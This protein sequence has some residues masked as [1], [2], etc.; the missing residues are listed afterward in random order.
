M[1]RLGW[2]GSC[3]SDDNLSTKKIYPGYQFPSKGKKWV[4]RLRTTDESMALFVERVQGCH[5]KNPQYLR[6]KLEM[7]TMEGL[8][9]RAAALWHLAQEIQLVTPL[10]R[11]LLVEHWLQAWADGS[12]HVDME[13]Q[14]MLLDKNDALDISTIPTFK[15]LLDMHLFST[16]V[17]VSS[18]QAEAIAVDEFNLVMKQIRYDVQVFENW[19]KK[20][21]NVHSAREHAKQEHRLA[22]HQLCAES[23]QVFLE[24]CVKFTCWTNPEGIIGEIM[25]FR[26]DMVARKLGCEVSK[27]PA[28]VFLNWSA[29]C[30]IASTVYD[31]QSNV[32][33][34]ATNDNMQSVGIVLYPVFTYAK[35]KLHLEETKVT[36][37]L[38]RANH[39]IDIQFSI[40][41]ADQVDGRDLRPMVYPGRF[42]FPSP[43][44]DLAKSM[45]F[46]CKL[47]KSRRTDEIKQ[48]APKNMKEIEDLSA[49]ALPPSIDLSTSRVQG[50]GKYSQ[51]GAAA[52]HAV[53]GSTLENVS[54]SEAPAVIVLD[55][56]PR[57][58]DLAEAFCK[59][60]SLYNSTTSLFYFGVC[61]DQR[62]ADWITTSLKDELIEGYVSGASSLPNN[63]KL[64]KDVADDLLEPLPPLPKMNL[65]IVSGSNDEQKR[66]FMPSTL[67]KKWQFHPLFG[68]EFLN[69]LDEFSKKHSVM[70]ETQP[71][72]SGAG[73]SPAKRGN[74][75]GEGPETPSKKPKLDNS[76]VV[77]SNKIEHALLLEAKVVTPK[78]NIALQIRAGHRI[79]ICNKAQAEA[80]LEA[81]SFVA[82][83]GRGNFK[84]FKEGELG[85]HAIEFVL[86]S[87]DDFVVLNGRLCSLGQVVADQRAKKPDCQI[88]Y[89]TLSP[90][91]ANPKQFSLKQ[92]HRVA[93]HCQT[94]SED[95]ES[96]SPSNEVNQGNVAAKEAMKFWTSSPVFRTL[97]TVR[98]AAKG[99]M[100]VK[101]NVYLKGTVNL[102]PGRSL[103]CSAPE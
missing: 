48:L 15:R 34:W 1:G 50:A 55:L 52:W 23:A 87:H 35:G 57:V 76:L 6:K 45:W 31:A 65:L 93:F 101:P 26:R 36:N 69:W 80:T 71:E 38:T 44:G 99:L 39:N 13:L 29:P 4:S 9:E 20:C 37:Q 27:I 41:F 8:A 58:G 94:K 72:P 98:W 54:L 85:D 18:V 81:D 32:L 46:S 47:R 79:Y 96:K 43:I 22:Q 42:V 24:G 77:E 16:P 49:D 62:E 86:L 19:E 90:S 21:G 5:E 7:V 66:L 3:W 51:L 88:C 12:D 82:G 67:V 60:R 10:P 53:L 89:H 28:L 2:E 17:Q 11:E 30:L 68:K 83:F 78:D 14:S 64:Q 73:P 95:S 63:Q 92:T 100:P 61:E 70:D 25:N 59:Q 33:A 56:Y 91:D 40:L 74:K 102:Q 97:W 75:D 103:S 84:L